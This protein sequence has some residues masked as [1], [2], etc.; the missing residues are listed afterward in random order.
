MQTRFGVTEMTHHK[1]LDAD[2]RTERG[3]LA[4]GTIVTVAWEANTVRVNPDASD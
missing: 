1:F 2:R 4:D 3:T